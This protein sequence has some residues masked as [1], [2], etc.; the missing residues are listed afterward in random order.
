MNWT[1]LLNNT[2][3]YV[4]P[5]TALVLSIY[6]FILSIVRNRERLDIKLGYAAYNHMINHEDYPQTMMLAANIANL[7]GRPITIRYVRIKDTD[8]LSARG[9]VYDALKGM[10]FADGVIF[11]EAH[12]K[13][14]T[15]FIVPAYSCVDGLMLFARCPGFDDTTAD[16]ELEFVGIKRNYRCKVTA[17]LS[18]TITSTQLEM[19]V[20]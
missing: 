6:N 12:S 11:N 20:P 9:N 5:I 17:Q 15:P 1:D 16:I 18:T 14:T 10:K 3:K 4:V 2:I 19:F 13:L 7:C 8:C